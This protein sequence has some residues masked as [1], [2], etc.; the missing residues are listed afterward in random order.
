MI[1]NPNY[2]ILP[3]AYTQINLKIFLPKNMIRLPVN[4]L[5]FNSK[6]LQVAVVANDNTAVLKPI[7]INRDFGNVLEISEGI[8][9]GE[10]V[11]IDPP[12]AIF[13]GMK[14]KVTKRLDDYS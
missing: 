1:D 8:S 12:D 11:I 9:P 10:E 4:T 13:S 5:I 3:G 14:V 2:E 7:T 6:G